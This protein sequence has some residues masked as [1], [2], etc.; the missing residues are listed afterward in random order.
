[1]LQRLSKYD[2]GTRLPLCGKRH[3]QKRHSSIG[4]PNKRRYESQV[5]PAKKCPTNLPYNGD[6][7]KLLGVVSDF[8]FMAP[9]SVCRSDPCVRGQAIEGELN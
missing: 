2:T 6:N 7:L 3:A 4:Q 1:M 9:F 5:P 8:S